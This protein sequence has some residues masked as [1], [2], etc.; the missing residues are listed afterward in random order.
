MQPPHLNLIA[1]SIHT[2]EGKDAF[3]LV[4]PDGTGLERIS[5]GTETAYS[6]HWSPDGRRIAYLNADL[7]AYLN[8]NSDTEPKLVIV[9]YRNRKSTIL[10][11]SG[12]TS[13][14]WSPD[15]QQLVFNTNSTINKIGVYYHE[16]D[17]DI[18]IV[19]LPDFSVTRLYTMP[20]NKLISW[21]DWSRKGDKILIGFQ[22]VPPG[23]IFF[24]VFSLSGIYTSPSPNHV[25]LFDVSWGPSGELLVLT[26]L[27]S[28]DAG[29]MWI[30][31][32]EGGQAARIIQNQEMYA[33]SWSPD[34]TMIAYSNGYYQGD[35][36]QVTVMDLS[37]KALLYVTP[38]NINVYGASWSPDSKNIMYLT[39]DG[40]DLQKES[41]YIYSLVDGTTT[42][43]IKD[44]DITSFRWL[45]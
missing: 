42:T 39:H 34:G 32:V 19:S 45:P 38:A 24:R 12:I 9:D 43:I 25:Y 41:L 1:Y 31:P 26:G 3:Y 36:S 21:F 18:N 44:A 10:E 11:Y 27:D 6:P 14:A 33:V 22:A 37:T 30:V 15:G 2:D 20:G 4:Q 16:G 23:N 5:I 28:Q 35:P 13:Y 40:K 17:Y 7:L 29:G 8:R